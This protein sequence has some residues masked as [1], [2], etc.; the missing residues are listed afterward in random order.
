MEL[1]AKTAEP[2]VPL[3]D[4]EILSLLAALPVNHYLFRDREAARRWQFAFQLMAC[5]GLRPVEVSHVVA[6]GAHMWCTW[7]KKA[8]SGTTK[9]RR[10]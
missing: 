9:P 7:V 10:L 3:L 6:R 5:Y 4:E 2:T 1:Q 8:G